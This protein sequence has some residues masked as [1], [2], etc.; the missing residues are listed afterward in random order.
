VT[1]DTSEEVK[2]LRP[3][4]SPDGK[5]IVFQNVE[6]TKFDV[7][8]ADLSSRE[9]SW[10]TNDMVQDLNPVW[11]RS[12]KYIYYTS[13]RSGGLNIWRVRVDA[14]GLAAGPPHQL[15]TGA[16]QDVEL[17]ISAR[18]ERLVFSILK[19]N[20]DIWRLPVNPAT[21]DPNGE[22]ESLI[23]TTREDSRGAWSPDGSMI[24]FNSDRTGHMNI[25]LHSLEQNSARQLTKGPGGD[26]QANWA[27]DGRSLAFF[28]SRA[29]TPDI[30]IVDLSGHLKQLT[31]NASI[32]I[33]P[34]F[35]P[36][37]RS[38]SYIS[39]ESG[40]LEVWV[41]NSDGS[42]QR[43]LTHIGAGGHFLRWNRSGDG[44]LFNCPYGDKPRVFQILLTSEEEEPFAEIAGGSHLSLSPDY[45]IF[46]DVVG[47]KAIWASPVQGSPRKLFEFK[48]PSVRIDY[49]FWS[50]DGKWVL[51]DRFSPQGGDV[52][53]MEDFE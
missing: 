52:W 23:G 8:I 34:F 38:I 30:W 5:K 44:I 50:P 24:A 21:G 28:S 36:D 32:N 6:R 3:R 11:S 37:G 29:G 35:S 53:M 27:P 46:I 13:Y 19:Q 20:A 12:G 1:S 41:M 7:R 10:L 25:W 31:R 18:G 47:H 49:P 51:F 14:N 4:W 17:S 39:D 22:P 15:T 33:N 43:Q 48:D 2:H 42:N 16:G 45:T 40:R 9:I 26:Y